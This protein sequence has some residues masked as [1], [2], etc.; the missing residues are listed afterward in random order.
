M[1][2]LTDLEKQTYVESDGAA[3]PFCGSV[4]IF[5]LPD[6]PISDFSNRCCTIEC[7]DCGAQ[8]IE[9]YALL[10]ISDTED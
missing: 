5:P 9:H 4:Q 7:Y 8:W 2:K 6:E 3:C 10:K 1:R